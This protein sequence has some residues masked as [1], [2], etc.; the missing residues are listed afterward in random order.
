MK[1]ELSITYN[2]ASEVEMASFERAVAHW[3]V[4]QETLIQ[5][6]Y[7]RIIDQHRVCA[8]CSKHGDRLEECFCWT[9][10]QKDAC[11]AWEPAARRAREWLNN[12]RREV[13]AGHELPA[14]PPPPPLQAIE[15]DKPR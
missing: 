8:Y 1:R 15:R 6:A 11:I 12:A 9:K 14:P 10:E 5:D 3:Q 2:F 7:Q 4:E 13:I